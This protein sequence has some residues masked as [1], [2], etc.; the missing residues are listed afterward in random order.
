VY[1]G[2]WVSGVQSGLGF[3]WSGLGTKAQFGRW[4]ENKFVQT[5]YVAPAILAKMPSWTV[6]EFQHELDTRWADYARI[7]HQQTAAGAAGA[8]A[9][10][11]PG[12]ERPLGPAAGAANNALV[13]TKG[14]KG[15]ASA[16][17]KHTHAHDKAG[18]GVSSSSSSAAAGGGSGGVACTC[19]CTYKCQCR[20]GCTCALCAATQVGDEWPPEVFELIK[21]MRAAH[22]IEPH[23]MLTSSRY[24]S[25]EDENGS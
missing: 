19:T 17:D 16:G 22:D 5:L 18:T 14:K 20:C 24:N 4:F 10:A 12:P 25:R 7:A 6:D 13:P 15:T 3:K 11:T 8:A 23:L 2:E 9:A 21:R 1:I